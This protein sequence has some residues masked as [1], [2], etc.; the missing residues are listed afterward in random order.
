[1]AILSNPQTVTY[2]VDTIH[3]SVRL[4]LAGF[5]RNTGC[6]TYYLLRIIVFLL[7]CLAYISS[8]LIQYIQ[9][10]AY[11]WSAF[12]V[13]LVMLHIGHGERI[14]KRI[15]PNSKT[16]VIKHFFYFVFLIK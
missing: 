1:M 16:L 6:P 15:T 9:V 13:R 10:Y 3:V 5:P 14:T 11:L 12:H 4:Q 7:I 2:F 8:M